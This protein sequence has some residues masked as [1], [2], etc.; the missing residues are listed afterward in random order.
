MTYWEFEATTRRFQ[1]I[2][3]RMGITAA[4]REAGVSSGDTVII[5]DEILEWSE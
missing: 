3:E 1:H 5:G 4:L 2:L